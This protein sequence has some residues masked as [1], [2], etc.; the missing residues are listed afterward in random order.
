MRKGALGRSIAIQSAPIRGFSA[1]N[2]F[3][4]HHWARALEQGS[5]Q[6]GATLS[7]GLWL[8]SFITE[9][10]FWVAQPRKSIG[11]C[12]SKGT[13]RSGGFGSESLGAVLKVAADGGAELEVEVSLARA[14]LV[15]DVAGWQNCPT[16]NDGLWQNLWEARVPESG[17]GIES[18]ASTV[19]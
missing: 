3:N 11:Q 12:G 6:F 16:R 1:E 9:G 13:A 15:D 19:A 7:E 10:S 5:K 18:P 4:G 8:Q 2:G 17:R 14:E